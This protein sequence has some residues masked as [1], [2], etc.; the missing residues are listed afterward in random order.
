M[1]AGESD[2]RKS[3]QEAE[4]QVLMPEGYYWVLCDGEW[5]VAEWLNGE[6][7]FTS[8]PTSLPMEGIDEIG[9]RIVR[10]TD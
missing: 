4:V 2:P 6:W 1:K 5:Y 8:M 3:S 7:W 9:E 10:S